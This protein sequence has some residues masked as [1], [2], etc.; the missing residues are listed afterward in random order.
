MGAILSKEVYPAFQRKIDFTNNAV[1]W[2]D[3]YRICL[4]YSLS[5][6]LHLSLHCLQFNVAV[7]IGVL[8]VLF[9][10]FSRSFRAIATTLPSGI[11]KNLPFRFVNNISFHSKLFY[12]CSRHRFPRHRIFHSYYKWS[13]ISEEQIS[14]YYETQEY[15]FLIQ[16]ISTCISLEVLVSYSCSRNVA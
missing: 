5:L 13:V 8:I 4:G 1:F 6:F 15:F 2:Y 11:S 9:R 10:C 3:I 14:W 16:A 12:L 7:G